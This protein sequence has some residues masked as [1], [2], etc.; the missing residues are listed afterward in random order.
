MEV[1]WGV[2]NWEGMMFSK[3]TVFAVDYRA[4]NYYL[5]VYLNT[6]FHFRPNKLQISDFA[7]LRTIY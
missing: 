4:L 5:R 3:F 2:I 1:V 7:V 6:Y